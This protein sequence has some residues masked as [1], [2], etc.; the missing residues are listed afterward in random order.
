MM[1]SKGNSSITFCPCKLHV[2]SQRCLLSWPQKPYSSI[3][4]KQS[5]RPAAVSSTSHT[6]SRMRRTKTSPWR[7]RQTSSNLSIFLRGRHTSNCSWA[8]HAYPIALSHGTQ[9]DTASEAS[10]PE[11]MT[12]MYVVPPLSLLLP[13][14]PQLDD[15]QQKNIVVCTITLILF[16]WRFAQETLQKC[17]L[18]IGVRLRHVLNANFYHSF[19]F[20]LI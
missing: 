14:L 20:R 2:T 6:A 12:S 17:I 19:C 16:N 7:A 10:L 4:C 18:G 15:D 13:S 8:W 5:Q 9:N 3:I 11:K 1:K